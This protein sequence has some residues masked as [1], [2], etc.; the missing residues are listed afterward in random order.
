MI[1]L[2]RISVGCNHDISNC[3]DNHAALEEERFFTNAE[4]ALTH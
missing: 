3:S 1:H 4:F 2:N